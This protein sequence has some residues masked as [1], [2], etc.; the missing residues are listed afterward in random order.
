MELVEPDA[1]DNIEYFDKNG[2]RAVEETA[3]QRLESNLAKLPKRER[4]VL[5]EYF[6]NEK[7][8]SEIGKEL[9]LTRERIRQIKEEAIG[10]L[11]EK[12][13]HFLESA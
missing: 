12:C 2:A 1:L 6:Y 7:T 10:R 3:K 13:G 8:L 5:T 9:N 11:R 4:Y